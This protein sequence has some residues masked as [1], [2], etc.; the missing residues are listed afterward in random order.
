MSMRG[1]EETANE[2]SIRSRRMAFVATAVLVVLLGGSLLLLSR[3]SQEP[4]VTAGPRPADRAC[5]GELTGFLS[6][7]ER[8][9]EECLVESFTGGSFFTIDEFRKGK[10]L[11]LSFWASWCGFCIK[12][13]PDFQRVYARVSGRVAFL[14]LDLLGVQ[15][16]TRAAAEERASQTGVRYPLGYDEDGELYL[17]VSPRLLMPTTVF[18]RADGVIAFRRF[19]PLDEKELERMIRT[20]LGVEAGG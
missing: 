8:L 1:D 19:G 7:G 14:G 13:M 15:A 10:P 17:R 5:G 4:R 18:V 20:H 2:A 6:E 9:P 3:R 16:E 11:V 12:E